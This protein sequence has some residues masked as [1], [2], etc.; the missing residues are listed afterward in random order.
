MTYAILQIDKARAREIALVVGRVSWRVAKSAAVLLG[1]VVGVGLGLAVT[2]TAYG[3]IIAPDA[4]WL[5]LARHF[6]EADSH[7]LL[8]PKAL[9]TAALVVG[10]LA[11]SMICDCVKK[12]GRWI[13]G[14]TF[15]AP[16]VGQ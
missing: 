8:D 2:L 3:V 1:L 6:P 14:V 10:A 15:R 12:M 7:G 9:R 4:L 16:K 13:D 5:G 11:I